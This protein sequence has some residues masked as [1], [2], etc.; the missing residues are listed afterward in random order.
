MGES[1]QISRER[2]VIF[3]IYLVAVFLN[4]FVDLGHK[5]IIQNTIFMQTDSNLVI[6]KIGYAESK[7][8]KP[9]TSNT[10]YSI[11]SADRVEAFSNRFYV[12]ETGKVYFARFQRLQVKL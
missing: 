9:A 1:P 7:F 2:S 4:A 8:I 6:D 12:E 5:I 10:L 11:N 3:S